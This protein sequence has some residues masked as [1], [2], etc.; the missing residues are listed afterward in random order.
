M[1]PKMIL[2]VLLILSLSMGI[3]C[4]KDSLSK[5][6]IY[7]NHNLSACGV[8]DPLNNLKWLS[9]LE[10]APQKIQ[11]I[12]LYKKKSSMENFFKIDG[13]N[14]MGYTNT[15]FLDCNG[16]SIFY[17]NSVTPPSPRYDEFYSDKELVTVIWKV[18]QKY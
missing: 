10:K 4:K 1:K 5:Y 17:W 3:N 2:I 9:D 13:L 15:T 6:E 14:E 8:E 12:S 18:K 7:E 11:S 16:N